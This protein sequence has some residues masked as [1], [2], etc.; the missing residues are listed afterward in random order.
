M[1]TCIPITNHIR[2]QFPTWPLVSGFVRSTMRAAVGIW[3]KSSRGRRRLLS[4]AVVD[5]P[6]PT[7]PPNWHHTS[8]RNSAPCA[9]LWYVQGHPIRLWAG[10]C[11]LVSLIQPFTARP[12]SFLHKWVCW[13]FVTVKAI[14]NEKATVK[15]DKR[16]WVINLSCMLMVAVWTQPNGVTSQP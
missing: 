13:G 2:I 4:S 15:S 3:S 5:M 6:T 1:P 7:T 10:W 12:R 11:P 9:V 14:L 16:I 8:A